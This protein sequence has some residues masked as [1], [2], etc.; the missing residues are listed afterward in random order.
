MTV[1]LL[2]RGKDMKKINAEDAINFLE[3]V[4]REGNYKIEISAYPKNELWTI[5]AYHVEGYSKSC[6]TSSRT[7][8]GVIKAAANKYKNKE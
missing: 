1:R 7:L 8:L 6:T 3:T 5:K 4:R 2:T